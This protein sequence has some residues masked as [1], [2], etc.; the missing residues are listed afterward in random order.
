MPVSPSEFGIPTGAEIRGLRRYYDL[1]QP[2]L[3]ERAGLS[4]ATIARFERGNYR[5]QVSS[6]A[7]LVEALQ[8]VE[9]EHDGN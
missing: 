4:R 3:A 2:E 9:T 1:T 6:V 5:G 8:A 7:A